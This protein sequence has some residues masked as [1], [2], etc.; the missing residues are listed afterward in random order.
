MIVNI[1]DAGVTVVGL[2][3]T[4]CFFGERPAVQRILAWLR[5]RSRAES[6]GESG[7]T[8]AEVA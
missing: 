2:L 4:L 5:N 6:A 1:F 7:T 8:S 3:L